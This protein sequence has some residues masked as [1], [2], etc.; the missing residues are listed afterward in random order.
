MP[1]L[2]SRFVQGDMVRK[3]GA[4]TVNA[5]A[6]LAR[7]NQ[8]AQAVSLMNAPEQIRSGYEEPLGAPTIGGFS[9]DPTDYIGPN[10]LAKAALGAKKAAMVIPAVAGMVKNPS[11]ERIAISEIPKTEPANGS[12]YW[13]DTFLKHGGEGD[14]DESLNIPA[15]SQAFS[16]MAEK[17]G[18]SVAG[19]GD[20]YVT[21]TKSFGTD[22]EGYDK[23]A[24]V[25][26]RI[27]DHSNVNR[28]HHFGDTDINIAP[29]DGY[30]RHTFDEAL[31]K[32]RSAY[33][34]DDLSTRFKD[35]E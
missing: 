1:N 3:Y 30:A 33:V 29:D 10:A 23:L 5:L 32:L 27:S 7:R 24:I 8:V 15:K 21:L 34:D 22:P 9:I 2:L 4:S 18:F 16:D 12:P 14:I 6:D 25:K 11:I 13:I 35:I 17:E 28:S 20:K 19:R 26:A 31:Q